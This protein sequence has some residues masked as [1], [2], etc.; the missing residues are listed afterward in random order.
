MFLGEI[1]YQ[2]NTHG[3]VLNGASR[4]TAQNSRCR[5]DG[6]NLKYSKGSAFKGMTFMY[7]TIPM[8][9]KSRHCLS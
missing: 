7:I 1:Y 9:F 2:T 4:V 3:P 5:R 8:L 6:I